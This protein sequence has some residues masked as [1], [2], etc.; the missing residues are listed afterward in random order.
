[1][2]IGWGSFLVVAYSHFRLHCEKEEK[3]KRRGI[4][5]G[6]TSGRVKIKYITV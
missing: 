4:E 6:G 2:F 5:K 1:M 3:G